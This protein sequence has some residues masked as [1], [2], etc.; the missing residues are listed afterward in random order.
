MITL[1]QTRT[2]VLHIILYRTYVLMSI[3][4]IMLCVFEFIGINEAVIYRAALNRALKQDLKING[5]Y[6]ETITADGIILATPT[7]STAYNLSSG[8]P[9]LTPTSSN[10]VITPICSQSMP[11]CSIVT[12]G[13]DEIDIAI[14]LAIS[15]STE[16]FPLLVIDSEERFSLQDKDRIVIGKAHDSVKIIKVEE[17]SFYQVLQMKL[18]QARLK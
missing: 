10:L 5:K 14:D 13:N 12:S 16:D 1:L 8:G 6:V 11:R 3:W 4:P 15:S 18:S 2:Y 17:N 9:I 7:G